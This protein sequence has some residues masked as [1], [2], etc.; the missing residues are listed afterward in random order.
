MI[1]NYD[2]EIFIVQA[3]THAKAAAKHLNLVTIFVLLKADVPYFIE[4]NAHTSIVR[5]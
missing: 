3:K 1:I 4:Y 5:T 2:H